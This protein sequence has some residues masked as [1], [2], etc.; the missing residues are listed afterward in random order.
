MIPTTLVLVCLVGMFFLNHEPDTFNP[1]GR[2]SL[3]AQDHGHQ[4]VTGY[5]TTATLVGSR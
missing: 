3:H 2:S 1:V 4:V 5:T